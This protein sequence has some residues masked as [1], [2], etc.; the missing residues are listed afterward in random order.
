MYRLQSIADYVL[1]DYSN[2]SC[3]AATTGANTFLTSSPA[4]NRANNRH[5]CKLQSPHREEI[6]QKR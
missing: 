2:H 4:I 1:E 6:R 5:A 3:H